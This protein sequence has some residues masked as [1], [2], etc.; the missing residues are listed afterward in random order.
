MGGHEATRRNAF[1]VVPSAD[2]FHILSNDPRNEWSRW[3]STEVKFEEDFAA[4]EH[5][6]YNKAV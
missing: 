3:L 2:I 1:E 6:K 4:T 5:I